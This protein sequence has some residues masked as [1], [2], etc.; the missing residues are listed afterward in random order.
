MLKWKTH[1]EKDSLY[2]TPPCFA[3]YLCELVLEHLKS[4]GGIA[5]VEK[6]NRKKAKM[7][8]DV[9]DKSNGFY[10]GV[11]KKESRSLMNVTFNLATPELEAKCVEEAKAKGLIGLKGHRDVG[12]MRASIYNAM[13]VEGVEALCEF[14]EEFK[15]NN[16]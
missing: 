13:S 8:Y 11:A 10:R 5:A 4:L 1:V 7:V 14:L 16:Q 12:G 6:Q 2:N 15:E 3:I 9:I